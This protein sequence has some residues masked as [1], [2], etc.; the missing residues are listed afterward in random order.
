MWVAVAVVAVVLTT[1]VGRITR[2]LREREAALLRIREIAARNAR[3]AS[4]TTLAAGAAHELGSPLGTIAV[5]AGDVAR[6][7]EGSPAFASLADDARLLRSELARCRAIL[8]RMSGRAER[9]ESEPGDPLLAAEVADVLGRGELGEAA[10]RID[11]RLDAPPDARL[12]S[13]SD[14]AAVVLPLVRNAVDASP[15][16]ARVSV[17]VGV[18]RERVRVCVRDGGHGMDAQTLA[19]AGEPFFTT[20]SAGRG[21]GLGLFVVR[22]HAERLGGTLRLDSAP[23]RGTSAHAEWPTDELA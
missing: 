18:D 16:D 8:D 3:L 13:R 2:A 9:A 14:F 20:R 21:T 10:H 22:L 15:V 7:S 5:I 17:E 11:L 1:F 23:G 12:G 6:A 4:L 19:R